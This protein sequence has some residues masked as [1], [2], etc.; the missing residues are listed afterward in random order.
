VAGRLLATVRAGDTVARLGGDEFAIVL[1]GA[2][3]QA[4]VDAAAER[5]SHAFNEPFEVAGERLRLR[6]SVGRA[7]WPEDANEIEALMRHAD[8]EMYREKRAARARAAEG[9]PS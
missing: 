5:V 9:V 4:V 3:S 8:A 7:M 2:G 6:A 1:S